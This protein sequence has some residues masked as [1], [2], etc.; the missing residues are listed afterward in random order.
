MKNQEKCK[1]L[2]TSQ[3]LKKLSKLLPIFSFFL[4]SFLFIFSIPTPPPV[5]IN[6]TSMSMSSSGYGLHAANFK[7][8]V[9][10]T[11]LAWLIPAACY[12]LLFFFFRHYFVI[13]HIYPKTLPI[14]SG[15]RAPPFQA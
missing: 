2:N 8:D 14:S 12:I 3:K 10:F 9:T 4:G 11:P 5:D 1:R 15:I 7:L 13:S 6:T